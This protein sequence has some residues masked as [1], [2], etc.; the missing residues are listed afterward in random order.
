M[1]IQTLNALSMLIPG[2]S[3]S[4]W[5]IFTSELYIQLVAIPY[6]FVCI[7]S[8]IHHSYSAKYDTFNPKTLRLDITSQQLL[9]YAALLV[10]PYN[11]ITVMLMSMLT[12]V[13]SIGDLGNDKEINVVLI[14][15]ALTLILVGFHY[16]FRCGIYW[17]LS[18]S[19][20]YLPTK[21]TMVLWHFACHISI[22]TAGISLVGITNLK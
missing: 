10:V 12:A 13:I 3:L 8:Y 5:W 1:H 15:N 18:L 2:I 19:L 21:Y 20:L 17:A 16:S 11:S 9:A 14:A 6:I 22:H 4:L 7:C